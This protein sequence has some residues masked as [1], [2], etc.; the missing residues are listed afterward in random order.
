MTR[1]EFKGTTLGLIWNRTWTGVIGVATLGFAI[2]FVLT[3]QLKWE[4]KNTY[5]N[6]KQMQF[7]GNGMQLI[8][9]WVKWWLLTF[10][11]FGIYGLF[12]PVRLRQ[13]KA[14]HTIINI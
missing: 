5:V 7:D 11:T 14:K 3:Q 9:N 4:Y 13:W 10:V 2:P 8:G 1:Q 6:G 12:I